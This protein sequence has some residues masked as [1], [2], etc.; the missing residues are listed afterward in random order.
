M[1]EA[2]GGRGP[3]HENAGR[4]IRKNTVAHGLPCPFNCHTETLYDST[5]RPQALACR[6]CG[7]I[8]SR[9]SLHEELFGSPG[10]GL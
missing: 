3:G 10:V 6:L 8:R 4:A 1:K 7:Q 9:S 2:P 5:G